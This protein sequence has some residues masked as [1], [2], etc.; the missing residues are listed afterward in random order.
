MPRPDNRPGYH[1]DIA[2]RFKTAAIAGPR[3]ARRKPTAGAFGAG[4]RPRKAR[5]GSTSR[6]R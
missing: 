4:P 5:G 6:R 2:I 3:P 1:P